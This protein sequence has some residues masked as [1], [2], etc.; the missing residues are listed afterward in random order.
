ML[1]NFCVR[2]HARRPPHGKMMRVVKFLC[3]CTYEKATSW[4]NDASRRIS[5]ST[6]AALS[7]SRGEGMKNDI[8]TY[9]TS[10]LLGLMANKHLV[11]QL[12]G[13]GVTNLTAWPGIASMPL[14][15]PSSTYCH[16]VQYAL[17]LGISQVTLSTVCLSWTKHCRLS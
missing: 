10:K 2:V 3:Q 1:S 17:A 7:V 12:E 13:S 8:F 6:Y 11:T 5:L 16:Y 15:T 14:F 4:Q 9:G